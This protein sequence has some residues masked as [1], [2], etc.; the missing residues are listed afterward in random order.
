MDG[1]TGRGRPGPILWNVPAI[2]RETIA[3]TVLAKGGGGE[4]GAG[5]GSLEEETSCRPGKIEARRHPFRAADPPRL[6]VHFPAGISPVA[7]PRRRVGGL[8]SPA[9][10]MALPPQEGSAFQVKSAGGLGV[11]RLRA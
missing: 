10:Y 9:R 5:A 11:V 7:R 6:D 1:A 2:G 8:S 4:W 3:G